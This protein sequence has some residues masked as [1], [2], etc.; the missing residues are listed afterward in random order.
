MMR[1]LLL[2]GLISRTLVHFSDSFGPEGG[3]RDS[4]HP[5]PAMLR[6]WAWRKRA[7]CLVLVLVFESVLRPGRKT[8]MIVLFDVSAPVFGPLW[9]ETVYVHTPLD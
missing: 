2:C 6:S 1:T 3:D 9:W 4:Q 8:M 5:Q 7:L